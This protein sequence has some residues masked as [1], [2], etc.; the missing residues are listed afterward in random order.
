MKSH[1]SYDDKFTSILNDGLLWIDVRNPTR[2]KMFNLGRKYSFHELNIEDCLSKIQIPKIDKYEDHVFVTLHF[3]AGSNGSKIP[4][5]SQLSIF[6][7]SNYLI[8]VH[9]GDLKPLA[10]M[11]DLCKKEQNNE[12]RQI[13]MGRSS[14]YLLHTIIDALVDDLF[15]ILMK[16]IGNLD[17]IEDAV[18]DEKAAIAR[19]ISLLRREITT[20]RRVLIPL[21]RIIVSLTR[22][23]QKFS[24]EDLTPY[25]DDIK[26]HIDKVLDSLEESKETIEI[27][28]DTDFMLS[29]EKTNKII[30]IL[31]V[32]FTLSIPITIISTIYGMNI[33]LP[34]SDLKFLGS[35]TTLIILLIISVALTITMFLYFRTLGWIGGFSR[36]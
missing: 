10:E 12:Y 3:P 4:R 20:M 2:E 34:G 16:V 19:E 23:I 18:Y 32:M 14:G 24:E 36:L 22:D 17:D 21:K 28:K 33:S 15:H 30:A 8:T 13:M 25:F 7:G 6:I 11:F 26:D 35:Y 31:T 1:E 29:T 5:I 27:Y 9:Q